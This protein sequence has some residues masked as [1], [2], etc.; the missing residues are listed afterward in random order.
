MQSPNIAPVYAPRYIGSDTSDTVTGSLTAIQEI[1]SSSSDSTT[2]K[3]SDEA[4]T[5]YKSAQNQSPKEE[6]SKSPIKQV[7][8]S[9]EN[10]EN[11]SPDA[12]NETLKQLQKALEEAQ[13]R[14]SIALQ[15]MKEAMM[16]MKNASDET[17]RI[18]AMAKV[19][20]A[21]MQVITAQGEVLAIYTQ[22]NELLEAQQK[23][24]KSPY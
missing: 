23:A 11:N 19:Q 12:I 15:Q 22:M 4:K 21:Q 1:S 2:V 5:R 24:S 7:A 20:T 13:K 9:I 18:A 10:Q 8:N 3:L 14:L 17:A 6:K 16:E